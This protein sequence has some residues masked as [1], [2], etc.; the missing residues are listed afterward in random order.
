MAASIANAVS[1]QLGQTIERIETPT[2]AIASPVKVT[3]TKPAR[4]PLSASS[5][6]KLLSLILGLFVGLAL[7]VGYV[8][9]RETLDNTVRSAA[10]LTEASGGPALGVITFDDDAAN[11]PLIALDPKSQRAEAMRVVRT[12]LQ[13]VDVDN[14]PRCVV[15]TSSLPAEGK[16]TTACNLAITFA[17]SG[18]KVCIIDG[19]LRR[20][21]VADYFGIEGS[22]GLTNLLA[23][24]NKL[25]EVFVRWNRGLVMVLPAGPI[26][27]N[28]AELLGSKS[29]STLLDFLATRFD[30]VIIDAPPLLPVTDAAIL[31]AASDGAVLVVRYGKTS[32]S[33]V[34]R[35]AESLRSVNAKLVGTV[36]NFVPLKARGYGYGYGY[37]Y[38]SDSP[39][40]PLVES[41]VTPFPGPSAGAGPRDSAA[42]SRGLLRRR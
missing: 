23:G 30:V 10:D 2:G 8:V 32:R 26:P 6:K 38:P 35:A 40:I 5:P 28:P 27:P 7:G 37:G 4:A 11:H 20:P 15:I 12:N 25:N 24:Q 17:L 18:Q 42:Q 21:K 13:F 29:M 33:E 14:P 1:Q 9:M 41:N 22:I 36:H 34:A 19:D 39:S 3:L 31:A 16:T